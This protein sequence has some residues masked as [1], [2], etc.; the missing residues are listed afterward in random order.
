MT[1]GE[2]YDRRVSLPAELRPSVEEFIAWE[3]DQEYSHEYVHGDIVLMSGAS[4]AHELISGELFRTLL[5]AMFETQRP[6][7]VFKSD[8]ML[9]IGQIVRQPD[10]MVCCA[11]AAHRLYED[12]AVAI[13]EVLSPSTKSIDVAD[14]LGEYGTLRSI[15]EYLIIDPDKRTAMLYRRHDLG[16]VLRDEATSEGF[17]LAGVRIDL[18]GIFDYVDRTATT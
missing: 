16:W 2:P 8:R 1:R 17:F 11:P 5:N 4:E 12:D 18:Q 10:V 7:R 3:A 6:C 13:A 14:K 9:R 15:T